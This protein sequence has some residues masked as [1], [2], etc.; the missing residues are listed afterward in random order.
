M[1][2]LPRCYHCHQ[3]G[4][5]LEQL[6]CHFFKEHFAEEISIL[7]PVLCEKTGKQ[8]YIALHYG[9]TPGSIKG[10]LHTISFDEKTWQMI[11]GRKDTDTSTPEKKVMKVS[12]IPVKIQATCKKGLFTDNQS[13]EHQSS[14][15]SSPMEVRFGVKTNDIAVGTEPCFV[16]P[17][18]SMT[19]NEIRMCTEMIETFP[20][21]MAYLRSI[22]RLDDWRSFFQEIKM[23]KFPSE[24]IALE[25]FLDV[26]RWYSNDT[27]FSMRYNDKVK[28]F[29]SLG[30]K[31]FKE[32]FLR[33][34]G[35]FKNT[36][37][38]AQGEGRRGELLVSKSKLN[39]AIPD[40]H[41][42]MQSIGY[43]QMP[44]HPQE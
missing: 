37:H 21:V 12:A 15:T 23:G 32:K 20:E 26:V 13:V 30:H 22:E 35:G 28:H 16:V 43:H 14:E 36:G 25:L 8:K 10:G 17:H 11:Y 44:V 3:E 18:G 42:L 6:L 41:I 19:E 34:M 24:N 1:D 7:K 4:Q 5:T 29:W 40:K 27:P 31:L 38:I 33:F 9:K 2:R 39:F